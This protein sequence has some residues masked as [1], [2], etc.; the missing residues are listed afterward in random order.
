MRETDEN[1]Y[2]EYVRTTRNFTKYLVIVTIAVGAICTLI[3]KYNTFPLNLIPESDKWYAPL[4]G[5]F[6][7]FGFAVILSQIGFHYTEKLCK[8]SE[9]GKSKLEIVF[10]ILLFAS[11][12]IY[13]GVVAADISFPIISRVGDKIQI[14]MRIGLFIVIFA[15]ISALFLFGTWVGA[16]EII[17][18]NLIRLARKFDKEKENAEWVKSEYRT[19]KPAVSISVPNQPIE[20]VGNWSTGHCD[21]QV[22][23]VLFTATGHPP[24]KIEDYDWSIS[25]Q[26]NVDDTRLRICDGEIKILLCPP[27]YFLKPPYEKPQWWWDA[28]SSYPRDGIEPGLT[29]LTLTGMHRDYGGPGIATEIAVVDYD[30]PDWL[31]ENY[32]I[33]M[34]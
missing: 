1:S 10:S 3:L 13:S 16:Y 21:D 4:Y 18:Y 11:I 32:I 28:E 14:L 19:G 23:D 34:R 2:D 33:W 12:A 22:I 9:I 25:S 31:K 24:P 20:F 5:V 8:N 15:G 6:L 30:A 26:G 7:V 29:I 27:Y 17:D